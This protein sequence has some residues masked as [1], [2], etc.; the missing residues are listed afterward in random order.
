MPADQHSV[1][2]RFP[3]KTKLQLQNFKEFPALQI[4]RS[5]W[6]KVVVVV[7]VVVAAAAHDGHVTMLTER[8]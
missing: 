8:P 1:C 4:H 5:L 7:V 3:S 6:P 2:D